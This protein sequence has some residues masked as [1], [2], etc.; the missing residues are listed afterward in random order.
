[1]DFFSHPASIFFLILR[2]PSSQKKKCRCRPCGI[3]LIPCCR[4]LYFPSSR[5][6]SSHPTLSTLTSPPPSNPTVHSAAAQ[7]ALQAG[8]PSRSLVLSAAAAH[9]THPNFV[10]RSPAC[11]RPACHLPIRH[12]PA[13]K[14]GNNY[15]SSRT[16]KSPP[17]HHPNVGCLKQMW[18]R[19]TCWSL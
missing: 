19:T 17:S 7:H 15:N 18:R 10:A 11:C 9:P 8:C 14:K 5:S 3:L 12:R 1:M 4:L 13:G 6:A 2:A 16:I